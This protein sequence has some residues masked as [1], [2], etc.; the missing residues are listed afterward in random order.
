VT[1]AISEQ[2]RRRLPAEPILLADRAPRLVDVDLRQRGLRRPRCD[3]HRPEL[4]AARLAAVPLAE[5]PRRPIDLL[6]PPRPAPREIAGDPL[7]VEVPAVLPPAAADVE[8]ELAERIRELRP[9]PRA[10]DARRAKQ[11]A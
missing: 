5:G 9:V 4:S 10:V 11:L 3:R 2:R 7:D 6:G 8:A 1:G